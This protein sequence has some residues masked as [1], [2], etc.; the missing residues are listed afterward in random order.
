LCCNYAADNLAVNLLFRRC[1]LAV[2]PLFLTV[3]KINVF[4]PLK[5]IMRIDHEVFRNADQNVTIVSAGVSVPTLPSPAA[6]I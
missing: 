4:N 1:Y 6:A 3:K 5:G 2:I